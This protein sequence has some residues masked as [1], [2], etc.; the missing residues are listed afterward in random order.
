MQKLTLIGAILFA[1]TSAND[2]KGTTPMKKPTHFRGV[3]ASDSLMA[4]KQAL[5]TELMQ[6]YD[7]NH[8][9]ALNI[10]EFD[11]YV[12]DTLTGK[13]RHCSSYI[14]RTEPI[15]D[16][17][18]YLTQSQIKILTNWT[19]SSNYTQLFKSTRGNFS[20]STFFQS[21]AEQPN[22]LF[23]GETQEGEFVGGYMPNTVFPAL[24]TWSYLNSSGLFIFNLNTPAKYHTEGSVNNAGGSLI[25]RYD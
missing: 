16:T 6:C 9:Q 2:F 13:L 5:V 23:I 8:D 1:T 19:S 4:Q 10:T 12:T 20:K 17:L 3:V 25:S 24:E 14:E 22:L 21:V 15:A 18:D 11:N 7:A